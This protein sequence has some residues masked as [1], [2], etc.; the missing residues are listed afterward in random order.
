MHGFILKER[1][2]NLINIVDFH[3]FRSKEDLIGYYS[4]AIGECYEVVKIDYTIHK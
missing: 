4:G 1:D 2:K 3:V